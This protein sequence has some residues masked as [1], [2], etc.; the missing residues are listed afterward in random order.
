[1]I[2]IYLS[3]FKNSFLDLPNKRSSHKEPITNFGGV[4]IVFVILIM[5]FIDAN[6]YIFSLLPLAI[7]GFLDDRFNLPRFFRY[8]V[9]SSTTLII[10][11]QSSL[12]YLIINNFDL[13]QKIAI[14]II[15]LLIGTAIINFINFMDGIDGMVAGN[16]FLIFLVSSLLIK[17]NIL[18]TII[19]ALLGFLYWNWN[20]AKIFLGDSGSTFLGSLLVWIL[21]NIEGVNNSII[22][23]CIA[24]PML[25][26]AFICILR[27]FFAKQ[28][29]F[30]S[31][32]L[33]LY[34]R[35]YKAGWSHQKISLIYMS[36]TLALS[37]LYM[38]F[39]LQILFLS[40]FLICIIGIYMDC[41]IAIPFNKNL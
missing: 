6:P 16:L 11:F 5:A 29:I 12:N 30:K 4:L 37:V 21:F 14:Y 15:F 1:L 19:G 9:Q 38:I 26:D 24:S 35:L 40:T 25:L 18:C 3:F 41:Y 39:G 23:C 20:P 31:H 33:H 32:S 28:N 10:I 8:L 22:I 36:S 34:Q 2:K 17:T 27:R 13:P 7:V